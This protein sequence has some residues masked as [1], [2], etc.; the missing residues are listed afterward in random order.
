MIN[1]IKACFAKSSFSDSHAFA[2]PQCHTFWHAFPPHNDGQVGCSLSLSKLVGYSK[3]LLSS[4]SHKGS[5]LSLSLSLSLS[6]RSL[7]RIMNI[8]NV[9][10]VSPT[11]PS[12]VVVAAACL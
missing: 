5:I 4:F 2:T 11:R 6:P 3:S 12:F 10:G 8:P 7:C 9:V 1:P